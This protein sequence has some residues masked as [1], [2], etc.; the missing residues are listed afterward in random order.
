MFYRP[1]QTVRPDPARS[2]A[3]SAALGMPRL[4]CDVM[5]ARGL[6]TPEAARAVCGGGDASGVSSPRAHITSH[7][8]RGMPSAAL[9]AA[10]REIGR[11]HV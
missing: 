9:S 7:T 1:W 2:A 11:A 6:D 5:C 10:E 8:R 4:V 3:L